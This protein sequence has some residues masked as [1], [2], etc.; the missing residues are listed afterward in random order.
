[1]DGWIQSNWL[2]AAVAWWLMA[3][4]SQ[5]RAAD[6]LPSLAAW[7]FRNKTEKWCLRNH[8]QEFDLLLQQLSQHIAWTDVVS[9]V[10][11]E[12]LKTR[13]EQNRSE[14]RNR[15]PGL[16]GQTTPRTEHQKRDWCNKQDMEDLGREAGMPLSSLLP[17]TTIGINCPFKQHT[18]HYAFD[19]RKGIKIHSKQ[20]TEKM[21]P[22]LS[23]EKK[24]PSL[25]IYQQHQHM[26]QNLKHLSNITFGKSSSSINQTDHHCESYKAKQGRSPQESK[27]K[28]PFNYVSITALKRETHSK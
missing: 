24:I 19:R 6:C 1:M 17:T 10:A 28:L 5:D 23:R 26:K 22:W 11:Q 20:P 4:V 13:E 12:Q 8:H 21:Q 3:E 18:Q 9:F 25:C 14:N 15:R 27:E 16:K 2:E 7:L